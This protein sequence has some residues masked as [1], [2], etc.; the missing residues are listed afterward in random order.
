MYQPSRT[1]AQTA[2]CRTRE[3]FKPLIDEE[4][5]PW[6]V[7]KPYRQDPTHAEAVCVFE[8]PAEQTQAKGRDFSCV[9]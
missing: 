6:I 9:V 7:I 4:E 8:D 2:S 3:E 1:V 5:E